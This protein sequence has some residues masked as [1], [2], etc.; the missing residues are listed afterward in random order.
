METIGIAWFTSALAFTVSMCATPGPN[1]AMVTAS[2]ATFG[3]R[4]TLPHMLG[5]RF[6]VHR[7]GGPGGARGG[8]GD[9]GPA[10]DPS[11][12]ALGGWSPT[13][14]SSPGGL[15]RRPKS[16]DAARAAGRPLSFFQA[17]LFQ[18]VNPKAWITALGAV[19]TY[20]TATGS[21]WFGQAGL[22][23]A[24]FLLVML[25]VTALWTLG[26]RGRSAAVTDATGFAAVQLGDGGPVGCRR[27]AD[28]VGVYIRLAGFGDAA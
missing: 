13:C 25:P 28:A 16:P 7:D 26:R 19:V 21:A 5:V 8:R 15:L 3:F 14:C 1:N 22:L 24:M 18:W 2:G 9:C 20:T 10:L 11:G 4:A 27:G 23:T 17:A 6:R 12:I